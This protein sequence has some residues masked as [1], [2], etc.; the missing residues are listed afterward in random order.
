MI[1]KVCGLTQ[2]KN[3]DD[4]INLGV[5]M[6]GLNF[7]PPSLRMVHAPYPI[8]NS[9]VQKVG[10]FVNE[11]YEKIAITIDAFGLDMVQLHGDENQVKVKKIS[12][13]APVVKVFRI[14]NNF[15]YEQLKADW[16]CSFFLFDTASKDYGGTGLKFDWN[17]LEKLEISSPFLLSGG[18]GSDDIPS[19]KVVNHPQFLGIDINSKFESSPG[20]KSINLVRAFLDKL[21]G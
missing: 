6:I 7:Y 5:D 17:V 13:L 8:S 1:I 15:D 14:G 12:K 20:V 3:T 21:H 16:N 10:V 4:I 9:N 19:L 11:T 2:P 18:I